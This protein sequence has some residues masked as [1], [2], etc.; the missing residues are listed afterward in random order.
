MNAPPLSSELTQPVSLTVDG[1]LNPDAVGWMRQPI[2]DTSGIDGRH[3]WCRNKRWEYWNVIT[4]TH[5]LALTASSIDYAGVHEVWVFD[6]ATLQSWQV[7]RTDIL[8]PPDMPRSLDE[9]AIFVTSGDL[10]IAIEP[11]DKG[12]RLRARIPG[13]AFDV[14]AALPAGH[15]RLGVVVPWSAKRFQYTV[16]DIARPAMGWVET[17][18]VRAPVPEGDSWATLDH[19]RGRW[20]YDITWNWG[21]A[22]GT[23]IHEGTAHILGLQIGDKWTDG[24]GATENSIYWDGRITKVGD[25]TWDYDPDDFTT[26]WRI[27]GTQMDVTLVPFYDKQGSTSMLVLSSRSDQC[28]GE[29]SGWV[30]PEGTGR[31]AFSGLVGWAE[32]VH[33][34]W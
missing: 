4:P 25:L 27:R 34:R 5:I 28:F 19:G 13:A 1:R 8:R 33:N 17:D 12:T 22:A 2:I 15:E 32:E 31:V 23:V 30:Q 16:K 7:M 29:Y 9:G 11:S 3:S 20:P 21:A 18:G 6:R 14:F 10:H 26:P 24:T